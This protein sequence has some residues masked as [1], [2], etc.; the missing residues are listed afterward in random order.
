MQIIRTKERP[1]RL[2]FTDIAILKQYNPMLI[3]CPLA[4]FFYQGSFS[5]EKKKKK[6]KKKKLNKW[7]I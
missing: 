1:F 4:A 7:I 6:K 2:F 5:T 3:L